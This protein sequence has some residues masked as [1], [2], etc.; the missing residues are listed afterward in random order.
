MKPLLNNCLFFFWFISITFMTNKFIQFFNSDSKWIKSYCR[1][2]WI[3]PVL[4]YIYKYTVSMNLKGWFMS[5]SLPLYQTGF[6]EQ[7]FI[8]FILSRCFE[9]ISGHR[10]VTA[11][12]GLKWHSAGRLWLC[13]D[14][15]CCFEGSESDQHLSAEKNLCLEEEEVDG[16]ERCMRRR[17]SQRKM[18]RQKE[19]WWGGRERREMVGE[20]EGRFKMRW[21]RQEAE[22]EDEKGKRD[23]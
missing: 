2:Y 12:C 9:V 23:Y 16:R 21:R 22:E 18:W 3:Y 10:W 5:A 17:K 11:H 13:P 15:F 19:W 14:L 20:G 1:C 4:F 6:I 7:N 8:K